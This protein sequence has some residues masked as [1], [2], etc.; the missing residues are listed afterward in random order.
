MLTD[1]LATST[2][3]ANPVPSKGSARRPPVGFVF[4]DMPGYLK[5]NDCTNPPCPLANA[6]TSFEAES[7]IPWTP[8]VDKYFAIRCP[9]E[10][11]TNPVFAML[12]SSFVRAP[13]HIANVIWASPLPAFTSVITIFSASKAQASQTRLR[14][15][16]VP[17]PPFS[18]R[19]F[20]RTLRFVV[21]ASQKMPPQRRQ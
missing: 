11:L 15:D 8:F 7:W 18:S 12:Y 9:T 19:G 1:S 10:F 5:P 6:T 2:N 16:P 21:Q 17:R 13:R 14:A 20:F 4:P 3:P